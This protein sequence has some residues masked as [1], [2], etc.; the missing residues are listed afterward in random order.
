MVAHC[1]EPSVHIDRFLLTDFLP[2]KH[3]TVGKAVIL[4]MVGEDELVES[5]LKVE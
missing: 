1:F 3:K 2:K 4:N 5:F